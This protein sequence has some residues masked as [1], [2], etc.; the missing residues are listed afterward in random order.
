NTLGGD[1]ALFKHS[2]AGRILVF[3]LGGSKVPLPGKT[4]EVAPFSIPDGY[5]TSAELIAQGKPL[6]LI[7]CGSC[8]GLHGSTPMLPDLRRMTPE[9]HKL[10]QEIVRGGILE[11]LGMSSFAKDL[12]KQ[13]VDA[14]HAY[15][16][17]EARVAAAK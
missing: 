13:E 15:I 17:S 11:P 12:T 1:E 2:N 6:Y 16:I 10:F 4:A 3:T 7:Q 5:P 8:H 14:I 9:K